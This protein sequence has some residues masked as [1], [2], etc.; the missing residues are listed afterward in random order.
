MLKTYVTFTTDLFETEIP[1]D[2]F[3]NPNGFGEDGANWLANELKCS[4][5]VIGEITQEDWG[6]IFSA[7]INRRKFWV[8]IGLTTDKDK[9]WLCF[10][11][12]TIL[13]IFKR[14]QSSN[15]ANLTRLCV[16]IDSILNKTKDIREIKWFTERE[17]NLTK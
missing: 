6:W 16:E 12:S 15:N 14:F 2:N 10:C 17:Y 8:G 11:E 7:T 9:R 3:I 13:K 1:K 4:G 5:F